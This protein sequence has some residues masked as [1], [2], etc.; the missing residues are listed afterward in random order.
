MS[1]SRFPAGRASVRP[2]VASCAAVVTITV[3]TAIVTGSSPAS[4]PATQPAGGRPAATRPVVVDTPERPAVASPAVAASIHDL[5]ARIRTIND[6]DA[7]TAGLPKV[8][9]FDLST[10]VVEKPA[11]FSLLGGGDAGAVTLRSL[12]ERLHRARDDRSVR[13]VLMTLNA[14]GTNLAQSQEVRDALI[15]CRRAGKKTFVYADG[16]DTDSYTIASGAT[17]VCLLPGGE[18]MIPGVG[19][20]TMYLKGLFDKLGVVADY[21]QIGAYKGADEEYTRTGPSPAFA[22]EINKLVDGLYDQV[23]TGIAANRNLPVSAVTDA[24]DRSILTAADAKQR[25][26]VDH[27]VDMDGLRQLMADELGTKLDVVDNYGAAKRDDVDLSSP[28]AL[29]AM[30]AKKP[31]VSSKPAVALVFADGVI[32]DGAGGGG[33]IGGLTGGETIGSDN[34]RYAMREVARDDAIKAVVI[35]INSPGG[36]ALASEAMWQAVRRVA[37]DKPVIVSVGNMAASGGYYLASAGDRI[38]ADPSAIVGSIGVVGGKFVYKDLMAKFGVT[39]E[40]F[41]RGHNSDMFGSQA[42]FSDGQRRMV[43]DWMTQTYDQ[44][45]R[46]VMTTR[47]GKIKAIADVAQGRVFVAA[48][49]KDLGIVDEIGGLDAAITYAAGQVDLSGDQFDVRSRP[50]PA[51]AG[52]RHRRGGRPVGRG[53][54]PAAGGTAGRAGVSPSHP[55]R[56]SVDGRRAAA[57]HAAAPTAAGRAGRPVRRP[58]EVKR[59]ARRSGPPRRRARPLRRPTSVGDALAPTERLPC[60]SSHSARCWPWAPAWLPAAACCTSSAAAAS[61]ARSSSSSS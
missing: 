9:Y 61:S 15:E 55:A 24:V 48:T 50:R 36:S 45:T 34:I 20:Q 33:G 52:G 37:K 13:A 35:R 17:N 39:T 47:T 44:F 19:I 41:T 29:F 56:G 60:R 3:T 59:A 21:V 1:Q 51:D 53:A 12:V 14:P 46:R 40:E 27:L 28:F 32:V 4:G 57:D 30:L 54:A 8:A 11:D 31:A 43:R 16:Y 2:R 22:G 18:V 58:G 25:G 5:A 7:A 26:L 10:P 23:V 42:P 6:G 38:F 49:A